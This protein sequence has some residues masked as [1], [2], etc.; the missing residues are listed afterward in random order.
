MKFIT[1]NQV[2]NIIRT[3]CN[4]HLQINSFV[5]GS[6]TDISASD[7]EQYTMVWCDINDSQM[8]E[9][10]FTMNLSLYVLDIQRADNSNEIDVLSDTLSIGRDL[11]AELSDPIYQDYFNV[12]YDVNFGQVREGFPDVVN[13]WKLDIAL[14]LMELNDRCQVPTI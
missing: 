11:I 12:R 9:R 7:Q 13:G 10:M 2:L 5:F 6:I 1:L 3:I 14:D 8:S 4:N